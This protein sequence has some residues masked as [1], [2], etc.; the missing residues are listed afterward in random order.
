M[1]G[2]RRSERSIELAERLAAH[3]LANLRADHAGEECGRLHRPCRAHTAIWSDPE[4]RADNARWYIQRQ[5]VRNRPVPQIVHD[6]AKGAP[7]GA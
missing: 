3:A 5:A 1:F 7:R 4:V 6:F 2:K